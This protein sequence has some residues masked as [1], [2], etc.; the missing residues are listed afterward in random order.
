MPRYEFWFLGNLQ[1]AHVSEA[2]T[3]R[4][5]VVGSWDDIDGLFLKKTHVRFAALIEVYFERSAVFVSRQKLLD[6]S[7]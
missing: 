6:H 1:D 5:D 4:V 3:R 2:I 7:E